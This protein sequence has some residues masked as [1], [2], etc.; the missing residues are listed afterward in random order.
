MDDGRYGRSMDEWGTRIRKEA[1]EYRLAAIG[2]T[3]LTDLAGQLRSIEKGLATLRL[4]ISSEFAPGA[5][6]QGRKW[7]ATTGKVGQQSFNA[8]AIFTTAQANG[9]TMMDLVASGALTLNWGMTKL[10]KFFADHDI[11]LRSVGHEIEDGDPDGPHMGLW[12]KAGSTSYNPTDG[13]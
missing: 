8:P 4:E 11:E 1:R 13:G 3:Q 2:E 10:R 5:V 6:E 7:K 12:Y 9:L